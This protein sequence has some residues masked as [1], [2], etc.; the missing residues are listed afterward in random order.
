MP[1]KPEVPNSAAVLREVEREMTDLTT[2][3]LARSKPLV[4]RD[5]STLVRSGTR[6]VRRVGDRIEGTVTYNT[7]Y[8]ARQHEELS[9]RHP[10]GGQ[11]KYL[12][13]PLR[14]MVPEFES[15]LAAAM[16]RALS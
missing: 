12:E 7:P 4:P 9:Y 15:R 2:D 13:Q 14:A 6:E 8:A 11:A 1:D 5:K 16:R 10:R 3:L